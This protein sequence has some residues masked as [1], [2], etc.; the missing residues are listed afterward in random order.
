MEKVKPDTVQLA[1]FT[2]RRSDAEALK[3][4]ALRTRVSQAAYLREALA[5]LLAKYQR[6]SEKGG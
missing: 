6:R 5:D 1:P 2:L 3:A 4:L